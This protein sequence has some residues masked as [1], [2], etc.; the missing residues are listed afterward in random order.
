M[1]FILIHRVAIQIR[2]L[3]SNITT[4]LKGRINFKRAIIIKGTVKKIVFIRYPIKASTPLT[5]EGR[6][7]SMSDPTLFIKFLRPFIMVLCI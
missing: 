4:S 5:E 1:P 2:T 7:S 3:S 6:K